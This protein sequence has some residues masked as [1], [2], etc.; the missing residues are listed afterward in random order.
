MLFQGRLQELQLATF[1]GAQPLKIEG[2]CGHGGG[3]TQ[4]FDIGRVW[5]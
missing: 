1:P 3:F 5:G 2:A 4:N